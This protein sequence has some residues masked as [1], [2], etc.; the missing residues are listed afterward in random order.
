MEYS[1]GQVVHFTLFPSRSGP[2][3]AVE[4]VILPMWGRFWSLTTQDSMFMCINACAHTC[5]GVF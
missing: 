5:A 1:K 3:M 2:D 4:L